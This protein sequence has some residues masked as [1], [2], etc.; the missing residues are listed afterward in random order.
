MYRLDRAV[1]NQM[2]EYLGHKLEECGE[3]F[4]LRRHDSAYYRCASCA[5]VVYVRPDDKKYY[6]LL[7]PLWGRNELLLSCTEVKD[8]I[9]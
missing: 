9:E 7:K 1:H 5:T 2:I 4:N 6:V 3:D 8:I